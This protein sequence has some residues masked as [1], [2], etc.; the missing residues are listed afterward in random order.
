M[1]MIDRFGLLPEPTKN[2]LR[3]TRLK[4]RAE[5]LGIHKI[6]MGAHNGRIEFMAD[7]QVDPYTL[8]KLIQTQSDR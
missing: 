1:E 6:T 5:A 3:Q 8:I 7:T 2:L 4:L